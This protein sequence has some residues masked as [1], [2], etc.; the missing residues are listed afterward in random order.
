MGRMGL[1]KKQQQ[2]TKEITARRGSSGEEKDSKKLGTKT[3]KGNEKGKIS[4][5]TYSKVWQ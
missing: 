4:S 2:L 1:E 3:Q 5:K